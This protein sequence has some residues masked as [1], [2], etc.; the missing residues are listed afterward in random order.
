MDSE[1]AKKAFKKLLGAICGACSATV[2]NNGN[3]LAEGDDANA[4]ADVAVNGASPAS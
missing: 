3:E 2:R 4:G 1:A